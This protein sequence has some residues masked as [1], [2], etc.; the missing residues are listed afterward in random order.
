MAQDQSSLEP[1]TTVQVHANDVFHLRAQ[2][3]VDLETDE[4][5][6]PT[7][8]VTVIA[9]DGGEE[10]YLQMTFSISDPDLEEFVEKSRQLIEEARPE[11]LTLHFE[12]S[13]ESRTYGKY[14]GPLIAGEVESV[15]Q[16]V[17]ARLGFSL[18]GRQFFSKPLFSNVLAV[19]SDI[20][21]YIFDCH[22]IW[23]LYEFRTY[24][25]SFGECSRCW[26]N[27]LEGGEKG[28][29]KA[30]GFHTCWCYG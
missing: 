16:P 20:P 6:G 27:V 22:S 1:T 28:Q 18:D 7:A 2:Q 23:R 21:V 15:H 26:I 9:D 29:T 13:A 3:A 30:K 11:E 8:L 10:T 17:T 25:R 12:F 5:P 24:C 4:V 19:H 14:F